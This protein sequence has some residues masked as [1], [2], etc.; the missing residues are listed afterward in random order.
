MSSDK[1]IGGGGMAEADGWVSICNG[2]GKGWVESQ[3]DEGSDVNSHDRLAP[4]QGNLDAAAAGRRRRK[5]DKATLNSLQ[6]WAE[7]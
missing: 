6:R 7:P 5:S 3:E 2:E 4:H 1:R